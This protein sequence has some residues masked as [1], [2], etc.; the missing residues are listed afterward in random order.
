VST[1]IRNLSLVLLTG[2]VTLATSAGSAGASTIKP[3]GRSGSARYVQDTRLRAS[4]DASSRPQQRSFSE[5]SGPLGFGFGSSL[6]GSAPVGNSPS[7]LAVNASTHTIYVANG[8]NTNGP[9]ANGNTVSVIDARDCQARYV[10]RCKGPW[11]TITVGNEPSTIAIDQKTDTVYVANNT[12]NTVSVFNGATCNAEVASGC[13]QTPATV[14][15]GLGPLGIFADPANHTVYIANFDNTL[16]DTVSMLNSATCNA[17]DLAACPTQ[18][19]PTVSVGSAPDDVDVNQTSHTVYV[20]ALIGV[21]VFDANT[22]NATVLSGCG[23]IGTLTGDPNGVNSA[24]VDTATNTLYTA[25]YDNTVSAFDLR[26]CNASDLAGCAA[27]TPGTVTPFPQSGYENDL[28][29]A[30]D[31]PLHSVY[32]VYQKDDSLIVVDT[33]VCNGRHLTGCATL[34]P[35]TIHTGSDPESVVLDKQT[36]TVYT[37]NE[38]DNSVSVID[39]SRCNAQ[40]TSGC[41]HPAPAFPSPPGALGA[42]PAAHTL[43]DTS[44]ANSVSMIDTRTCNTH[45]LA[46]CVDTAPTVT[47]GDSPNAI[48][49]D[50]RTHT[51]YIANKGSGPTGTVSVINARTCNA[52]DST[53]CAHVQTLQVPGGNPFDIAVNPATDTVYVATITRSG[54]NILSVFNGDT[55]N[56]NT[57]L[58]CDQTPAT[59]AVADS[60]GGNSQ[61]R[62]AVNKATNT[63]Y[64]TNIVLTNP[65]V[66]DRVYV[67]NAATCDAANTSGCSQTPATITAGNNPEGIAVDP[68]TNTVYTANLADGEHAGTVSVINGATCNGTNTTGCGQAPPSV[69]VGFGAKY[70]AIDHRTHRVY[71]TNDQDTSVSIIDGNT[72]NASNTAGCAETPPKVAVGNY[73]HAIAIDPNVDSAYITNFDYTVSVI[74]LTH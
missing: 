52:T 2:L 59:L 57:T 4:W 48:A 35:P 56:A 3:V 33:N 6:V 13:D 74:P 24:K 51:V 44:G 10:A 21:A 15:V 1:R 46:G 5:F 18:P 36:E 62:I 16:G 31:A 27:Q 40:N 63:V 61:L 69:T 8:F 12:D 73:P 19:P 47:V 53:G 25:N 65:F 38:V 66:G 28:W 22:C 14:P 42:N 54:P 71:V 50:R 72:C 26:H 29:V 58:G 67:I 17:T 32:V 64:A 30:V 34:R 43:Y 20:G 49:I 41:R 60:G 23:A 11:P 39:A 37:A 45:R 55:C 70:M 7:T 68:S 9:N